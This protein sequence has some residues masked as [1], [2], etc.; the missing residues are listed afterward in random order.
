LTIWLLVEVR[1]QLI[2]GAAALE[3]IFL[4]QVRL[5]APAQVMQ[6]LLALAVRI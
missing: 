5:L 2:L 3:D 1:G 4:Q 6:Q